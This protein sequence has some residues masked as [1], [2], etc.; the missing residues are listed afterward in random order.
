MGCP[1]LCIAV[2]WAVVSVMLLAAVEE[3][4]RSK[5]SPVR[6]VPAETIP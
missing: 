5:E 4:R 1:A 6:P 3:G 2:S